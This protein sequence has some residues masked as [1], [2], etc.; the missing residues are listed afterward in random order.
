MASQAIKVYVG[1]DVHKSFSQGCIL[2]EEGSVILEQKFKND[3]HSMDLFLL[4]VNK[5]DSKIVLE[6]CS[7]WQFVYDYLCDA[8]YDVVLANPLQ[9]SLIAK[10]RKKTDRNDAKILADLLRTNLLPTSYAAPKDVRDERQ[11]TRH[12]ASLVYMGAQLKHKMNAILLRHG[13]EHGYSELFGEAGKEYLRSLD[14]PMCDRFELDN[15]LS[16]L[17][18]IE[19]KVDNTQD[20]VD[21]YVKHNPNARLLMTIPGISYYSALMISAEI[22]YI[23]RFS[24]SKQLISYAGLN[25]SIYQSGNKCISGHISKQGNRNLRWI[26]TQITHVAVQHDK[27]LSLFYHRIKKSRG[28]SIA[29]TATAR[30]LLTI[31]FA[32]LK[33]NSKYRALQIKK[34]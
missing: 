11:I 1:L 6:S 14:L 13:L 22:G 9:V 21:D 30:K 19:L 34:A 4:N 23:R 25:P 24:S 10:S 16:L 20:R 26:L 3:P 29:I 28:T 5:E 33:N 8:N 27:R 31:I 7:C 15:Y 32:M 2:D 17:R 18:H 12:R